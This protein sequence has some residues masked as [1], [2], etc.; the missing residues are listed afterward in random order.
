MDMRADRRTKR[1]VVGRLPTQGWG[2]EDKT[3][4]KKKREKEAACSFLWSE[5]GTWEGRGRS[6]GEVHGCQLRRDSGGHRHSG[7]GKTWERPTVAGVCWGHTGTRRSH[8]GAGPQPFPATLGCF[9]LDRGPRGDPGSSGPALHLL[10]QSLSTKGQPP[11]PR[12]LALL[13]APSCPSG[14]HTGPL[15]GWG[16]QGALHTWS[17][18]PPQM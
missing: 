15:G 17:Q 11:I 5:L 13:R 14:G 16:T 7:A 4:K 9:W 3:G 1:R 2:W 18:P 12:S 6:I 8:A 10:P